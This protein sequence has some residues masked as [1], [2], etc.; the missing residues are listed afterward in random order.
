MEIFLKSSS[1]G[2]SQAQNGLNFETS[3]LHLGKVFK[4]CKTHPECNQLKV[5]NSS[6]SP[7]PKENKLVSKYQLFLPFPGFKGFCIV[8]R[9]MGLFENFTLFYPCSFQ[10]ISHFWTVRN[11]HWQSQLQLGNRTSSS[12]NKLTEIL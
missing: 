8:L 6:H 12:V 3:A 4:I 1:W 7:Y 10:I 5:S 9:N 11:D 2:E